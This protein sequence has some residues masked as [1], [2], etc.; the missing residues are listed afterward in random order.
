VVSIQLTKYASKRLLSNFSYYLF[1][2]PIFRVSNPNILSYCQ[3]RTPTAS[4]KTRV[5]HQPR[6]NPSSPVPKANFCHAVASA[7]SL[8]KIEQ[9]PGLHPCQDRSI[10]HDKITW[11]PLLCTVAGEFLQCAITF[12]TLLNFL[13]YFVRLIC[14]NAA[15]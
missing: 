5:L 12:N 7:A 13:D 8:T 3:P 10:S 11:S 4:T 14:R 15:E 1:L 2:Q 9:K 6:L